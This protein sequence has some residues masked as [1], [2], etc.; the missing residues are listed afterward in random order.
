MGFFAGR[1]T[2]R[3][4]N[5]IYTIIQHSF[6]HFLAENIEKRG[7]SAILSK[8]HT[9]KKE[10]AEVRFKNIKKS[11]PLN[12]M[13][14]DRCSAF[15][16]EILDEYKVEKQNKLRIRLTIEELLLR[17]RDQFGEDKVFQVSLN[18]RL[19]NPS[20]SVE[21]EETNFNPLVTKDE[22]QDDWNSSIL[23]TLG[24][25]PQ[26]IYYGNRNIIRISIP[27]QRMNP[28]IR[29]LIAI[30]LSVI[31][32][33]IL[34]NL[35]PNIAD[36][37]PDVSL[38]PVYELWRRGLNLISGPVI[39][40]MV[41]TTVLSLK[42][43]S[44]KGVSSKMIVG[45]YFLISAILTIVIVVIVSTFRHM[46]VSYQGLNKMTLSE[47]LNF[48]FR[49]VPNDILTPFIEADT[50]QLIFMALMLG[51][52]LNILRNQLPNLIR[53][54]HQINTVCLLMAEWVS[55]L[56]PIFTFLL[57][58]LEIIEGRLGL[59]LQLWKPLAMSIVLTAAVLFFAIV[60]LSLTKHV[61]I[62]VL[63]SKMKKP[64]FTALKKGSISASYGETEYSCTRQLGIDRDFTEVSL[65]NGIVLYMP[66]SILGAV[67]FFASVAAYY[68]IQ[69]TW[70]WYGIAAVF[71]AILMEAAPPVPGVTLLVFIVI[72]NMLG[73]PEEA[74]IP[75]MVFDI[76]F[77]ILSAAGNQ[78]LLQIEMVHQSDRMGLLNRDVLNEPLKKNQ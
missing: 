20:L 1:E 46:S 58:G 56:V 47:V 13:G 54:V 3:Y 27:R 76:L 11:F 2:V 40:F 48:I 4:Y 78:M 69:V 45:R 26:F 34:K 23:N 37:I 10:K 44:I 42:R 5:I 60:R 32:A 61:P 22:V 7:F 15:V 36:G 16:E 51:A 25:R 62:K 57:L 39:F 30:A 19:G 49:I 28:V 43:L 55:D 52:M 64:F 18:R 24:V 50:P 31:I 73:I 66:I 9:Y 17:F 33:L 41:V 65:S 67:V 6:F 72:F 35:I 38:T 74:L 12:G 53:I 21:L 29:L 70:V 63:L 59:F 75:A 8:A 77:S 68:Q 14:I 71:T